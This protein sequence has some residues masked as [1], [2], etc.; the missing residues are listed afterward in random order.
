MYEAIAS[1]EQDTVPWE[2]LGLIPVLFGCYLNS[3]Q[4]FLWATI[5]FKTMSYVLFFPLISVL[6]CKDILCEIS[7]FEKWVLYLCN[8]I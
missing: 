4:N 6:C 1:S 7:N 3:Q 8:P 5:S 2:V